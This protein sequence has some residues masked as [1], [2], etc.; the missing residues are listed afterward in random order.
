MNFLKSEFLTIRKVGGLF[1]LVS[2]IFIATDIYI[3]KIGIESQ[4]QN[5]DQVIKQIDNNKY[6]AKDKLITLGQH[7]KIYIYIHLLLSVI[8]LISS[9]YFIK[10]YKFARILLEII[11]WLG[12]VFMIL[13]SSNIALTLFGALKSIFIAEH[14]TNG[15]LV[16]ILSTIFISFSYVVFN[17]FWI[18]PFFFIIKFFRNKTIKESMVYK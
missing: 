17:L 1:L 2:L 5:V 13:L 10:Q 8:T 7:F 9:I 16:K 18:L 15:N 3:I 11:S 6:E 4:Q 12:V 14:K